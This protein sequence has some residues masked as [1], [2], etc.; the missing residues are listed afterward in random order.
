MS[1]NTHL[2]AIKLSPVLKE[3]KENKEEDEERKA[4]VAKEE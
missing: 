4:A 3:E 1:S 2:N